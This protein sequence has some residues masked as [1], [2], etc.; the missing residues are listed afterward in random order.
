MPYR[1]KRKFKKKTYKR[2]RFNIPYRRRPAPKGG[3]LRLVRWSSVAAAN[4]H[5]VVFGDNT[6]P[7]TDG[8]TQ[9]RLSDVQGF[10]EIQSLFD[11]Y[12]IVKVLYRW[13]IIRDPSLVGSTQGLYPRINWRH[14]FNDGAIISRAQLYQGANMREV[15]MSDNR[16][17][18]K[19]YSIRPAVLAEMYESVAATGYSPKWRQWLDTNDSGALHYGIK[20]SID[21][22]QS[23]M[24]VR[25]E[26]KYVIEC[27]GIS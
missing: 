19:W 12:R 3:Y 26:A 11:N 17:A 15:W 22:N 14:D 20:Y 5:V 4:S 13:V 8:T 1:L 7:A 18:T 6:V 23:G 27:K 24:Q 10:G 9:F 25:M 2:R 16:Q 21:S